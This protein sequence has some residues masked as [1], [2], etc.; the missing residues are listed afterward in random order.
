MESF[1]SRKDKIELLNESI[2]SH[3]GNAILIIVLFLKTTLSRN[4]FYDII[5]ENQNQIALNHF[6]LYLNQIN[7][8]YEL[9]ELYK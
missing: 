6:K 3:D 4:E 5:N 1:K 7:D 9:F 8:S 2:K